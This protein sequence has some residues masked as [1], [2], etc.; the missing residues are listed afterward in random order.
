MSMPMPTVP[1]LPVRAGETDG[2]TR[3]IRAHGRGMA[4]QYP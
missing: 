2:R 1:R 3:G 4:M